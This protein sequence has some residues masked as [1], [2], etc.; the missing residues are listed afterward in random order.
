MNRSKTQAFTLIEIMAVIVVLMVLLGLILS[1]ASYVNRKIA[2]A[3]TQSEIQIL[4][5]AIE[6]YKLDTGAYPTSSVARVG[7][8]AVMTTA[9]TLTNSALLYSQLTSPKVYL[10]FRPS[11]LGSNITLGSIPSRAIMDPWGTPYNYVRTRPARPLNT[12]L[13]STA[14][15]GQV[16]LIT[17]DLWSYGPDL[18]NGGVDDVTNWQ[19]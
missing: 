2:A 12:G 6:N 11:Q 19:R 15:T 5:L 9:I 18:A 1:V 16:N 13:V 3:R 17:F 7:S 10:Q 4:I 8:T 14:T